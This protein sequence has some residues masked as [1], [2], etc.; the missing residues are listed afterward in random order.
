MIAKPISFTTFGLASLTDRHF[1]LEWLSVCNHHIG[2]GIDIGFGFEESPEE[3]D[4]GDAIVADLKIHTSFP[5]SSRI[6]NHCP[7][8]SRTATE[9]PFFTLPTIL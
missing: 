5:S 2:F 9:V 6:C 8:S 4:L 7:L 3:G 1:L